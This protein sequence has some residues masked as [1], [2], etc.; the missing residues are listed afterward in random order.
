MKFQ[1]FLITLT[2]LCTQQ[3]LHASA[4]TNNKNNDLRQRI[5]EAREILISRLKQFNMLTDPAMLL[6][7]M[8]AQDELT[9]LEHQLPKK[10]QIKTARP[11]CIRRK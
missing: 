1:K 3:V 11:C 8:Q 7:I 2:L 6:P 9:Y 4:N 5:S 10:V